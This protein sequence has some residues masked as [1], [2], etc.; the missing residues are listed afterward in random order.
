MPT[1]HPT[2]VPT[3][4]PIPSPS[5]TNSTP[6]P[7]ITSS[8]SPV[9]P[10]SPL[11]SSG[12]NYIIL[13]I[14]VVGLILAVVIGLLFRKR[15]VDLGKKKPPKT[16]LEAKTI[17]VQNEGLL[18]LSNDYV[19]IS[20]VDEDRKIA[21]AIARDLEKAGY[22][23]WYYERDSL[24]GQSYILTTSKAIEHSKAMILILSQKALDSNQVHTEVITAHEAGVHFVP[25]L[26]GIIHE[27]FQQ[28]T[29]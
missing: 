24:P 10:N 16:P 14:V 2:P 20:H 13:A 6:D 9:S 8:P 25:V 29:T 17:P 12:T 11:S 28:K 7:S 21:E 27:E 26:N 4:Q 5:S 18:E 1:T 15:L 23:T 19:F 3:T 22:A